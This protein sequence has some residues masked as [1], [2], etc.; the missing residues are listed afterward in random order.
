MSPEYLPCKSHGCVNTPFNV[1]VAFARAISEYQ[2]R[3]NANYT[4]K[5]ECNRCWEFTKYTYDQIVSLMPPEQRPKPLPHDYFWA[6]IL[7][8]LDKWKSEEYR[9]Y[10]GERVLVQRLLA[11]HDGH[12]YGTLQSTSPYAPT[13]KKGDYVRGRPRR[14]FE[15]LLFVVEGTT[16]HIIPRPE[17]IPRSRS[18]GMFVSPKYNDDDLMCAN[19]FC[20]NP[21][22][23]HIYSTMTY[24]KFHENAVMDQKNAHLLETDLQL[25]VTLECPLCGTLKI[26]DEK[27]FDGLY[28][29]IK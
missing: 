4:L 24:T 3:Y 20:S 11:Q 29:E 25:T 15:L 6:Y 18:V 27:S 9:A 21:S 26:I 12:W 2:L 16:Q 22:C 5:L 17:Q 1:P 10:L 28:K 14:S 7:F 13:L 19:I 8:D 23:H